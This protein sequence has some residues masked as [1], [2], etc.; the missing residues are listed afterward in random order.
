L[1]EVVRDEPLPQQRVLAYGSFLEEAAL[2]H[3]VA[4]VDVV[5]TRRQRFGPGQ[6]ICVRVEAKIR[7]AGDHDEAPAA[8]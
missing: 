4:E 5:E 1:R 7:N 2:T 8:T 3:Q 6:I